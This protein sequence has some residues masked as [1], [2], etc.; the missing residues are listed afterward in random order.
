MLLYSTGDVFLKSLEVFN[1]K[2]F[3]IKLFGIEKQ[4][5]KKGAILSTL[6][7]IEDFNMHFGVLYNE[8]SRMRLLAQSN[9]I[10]QNLR[11]TIEFYLNVY[12]AYLQVVIY[13]VEFKSIF[14]ISPLF[15]GDSGILFENYDKLTS[16][17][18]EHGK[19]IAP[20]FY[21]NLSVLMENLRS[22]FDIHCTPANAFIKERRSANQFGFINIADFDQKH[23]TRI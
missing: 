16:Y 15:I 1:E 8:L 5:D 9:N 7:S 17:M 21:R 12:Y 4:L 13:M 23:S 3:I 2:T 6:H 19:T 20:Q 22:R 14:K 11:A 18:E 10:S